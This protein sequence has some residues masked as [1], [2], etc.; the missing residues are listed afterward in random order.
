MAVKIMTN[1]QFLV[2]YPLSLNTSKG[3]EENSLRKGISV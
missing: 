1:I 3:R 2:D